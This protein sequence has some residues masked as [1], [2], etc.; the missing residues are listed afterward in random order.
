MIGFRLDVN[1]NVATG[2]VMRCIAIAK[3]IQAL[4][5]TC[6]FLLADGRNTDILEKNEMKYHVLNVSW[7]D[8]VSG[9]DAIKQSV[10]HYQIELL[11]VDSYVVTGA[12]FEKINS[13]VPVLY[14]DDMC[15]QAFDVSIAL[16]YSQWPDETT[17]QD[18]YKGKRVELLS[19]MKYMPLR[20]EFEP[21]KSGMERNRQIMITTGGTDPFHITLNVVKQILDEPQLKDYECVAVLGKMNQDKHELD[22]LA[23]KNTRL[24]VLQNI[25]NMGE[26]MRNSSMAVSAGGTS[27][28]ELCACKTPTV[29]IA[30]AEDH[31]SF[32]KKMQQHRILYYAGDVRKNMAVVGK[33]IIEYLV[34]LANDEEK[35]KMFQQNMETI[36]DG[37]GAQRIAEYVCSYIKRIADN[38]LHF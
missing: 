29:C 3:K 38:R 15:K 1:E 37:K 14:L 19:G 36:V 21:G 35:R 8:W 31:V 6:I 28:Y 22:V 33:R 18:L 26:I 24:T 25:S 10:R 2:H 17:L 27:I 32:A 7:Q 4:G 34:K 11:V 30:F 5:K 16:H 9:V 23:E 12:F 20:D 13:F